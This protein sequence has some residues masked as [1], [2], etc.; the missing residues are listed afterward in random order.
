MNKY[1][2][3]SP[4]LIVRRTWLLTIGEPTSSTA[5]VRVWNSLLQY[6]TFAP[7]PTGLC[8]PFSVDFRD[9]IFFCCSREMTLSLSHTLTVLNILLIGF[10]W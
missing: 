10:I 6:I 8:S 2:E 9:F 7:S 5:E 3:T 1:K 4:S